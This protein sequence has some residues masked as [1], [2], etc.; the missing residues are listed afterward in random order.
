M[1]AKR[2]ASTVFLEAGS[3]NRKVQLQPGSPVMSTLKRCLLVTGEC[4][5]FDDSGDDYISVQCTDAF[6]NT[7]SQNW[8]VVD[9]NWKALV[10]L[11]SGP[12]DL[13]FEFHR[14]GGVSASATLNVIYQPLLQNPP[15][16]LAVLVAKDSPLLIDCPPSKYGA[17]TSAHS[18]LDAVI[19]KFRTAALMWQ[20]LTAE[21]MRKKTLG[22]RSFRLE[23]EWSVD[24]LSL[25]GSRGTVPGQATPMKSVP[26]IHI[27][28]TDHTVAEL[29]DPNHLTY[30]WPRFFGEITNSL[31]DETIP[32]DAVGNDNNECNSLAR[33]CYIGQGAFLHKVGHAFGADHT[34]G[35][36]A[37]GYSKFWAHNFLPHAEGDDHDAKWDLQDALRFRCKSHFRL[38][39]DEKIGAEFT[40]T[41]LRIEVLPDDNKQD[42]TALRVTSSAGLA[43]VTINSKPYDLMSRGR[44]TQFNT[45]DFAC[46]NRTKPLEVS[47]LAMNG[48]TKLVKDAW[49]LFASRAWIDIPGST[50]KLRKRSIKAA[51]MEGDSFDEENY[52]RWTVL[53]RKRG[54]K[55][56]LIRTSAIDLRV[57]CTFDRVY[58]YYPDGSRQNCGPAVRSDGSPH[59][60]GG[61]AAQ[62]LDIP[63]KARITK[64]ELGERG[65]WGGL[66]RIRMTLSDGQTWGHVNA[67][68]DD[69][70]KIEIL[71]PGTDEKIVGFYGTSGKHSFVQ[72]FGIITAPR[73]FKIPEAIYDMPEL[74]NTGKRVAENNDGDMSDEG[75]ESQ[76]TVS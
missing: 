65:G 38:P 44:Y 66:D 32:G 61:H 23:E 18:N 14:A 15:L 60:F 2:T 73:D 57:G 34:T 52:V 53:L 55:G 29:R 75:S 13:Q 62:K 43:R 46:Y 12:N 27:I 58:V 59:T 24:T 30:S 37:R 64:V 40:H 20:A 5:S 28:R 1:V 49:K 4:P 71:E 54:A 16:H 42:I 33:A 6:R 19:A 22:R 25:N 21:D 63:K 17:V 47:A 41:K 31:S 45:T 70:G 39:G 48:K 69:N 10:L 26:K 67:N 3:A 74:Q 51:C 11:E 50:T 8:P 76:S 72:E 56:T 9:S 35:I 7:A 68:D 36:M